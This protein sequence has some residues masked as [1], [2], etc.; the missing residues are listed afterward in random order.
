MP[1]AL[2]ERLAFRVDVGPRALVDFSDPDI[3]TDE[4]LAARARLPTVR[5]SE[6]ALQALVAAALALGVHSARAGLFALHAARAHAALCG[7]SEV[8]ADD[9]TVAARLVLAPRATQ[10]PQAPASEDQTPPDPPPSEST[11]EA[12]SADPPVPDLDRPMD[13]VVLEA[14]RAVIPAGLLARI[15][16]GQTSG[17]AST[18]RV[19]VQKVSAQRGRPIGSRPGSP[20]GGN[21]LDLIETLR[22]AAP[23]QT[24]RRRARGA[25]A[26]HV[27]VR[28]LADDFRIRRF[29]SHSETTTIFAVDASGSSALN[30]LAEA[31][32]AVEL[33]LA[34]CYVRRDR[35]AVIAFRGPGAEVLLPPTRS[36]VRAKRGLAG[37]PGGGGTPLAAGIDAAR[38]VAAVVRRQGGSPTVVLLTDGRANLARDGTPGRARAEAE[39]L[40]AARALR[41]DKLAVV[42]VDTSPRPQLLAR[43]LARAMDARYVPLP[44][45]DARALHRAVQAASDTP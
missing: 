19:G 39:A 31:K 40:L 28:V 26:T 24:V 37:L 9:A 29:K 12:P 23:W 32:G 35:V 17:H 4:V 15:M 22:A 45:A 38:Q 43:E 20:G 44:Y 27:T 13:D 36:L 3:T 5:A 8:V 34:E 33:L 41:A 18:G 1:A 10:W 11:D 25:S 2:V 30:R 14:A 16:A 21:R 6:E 42:L 7:R